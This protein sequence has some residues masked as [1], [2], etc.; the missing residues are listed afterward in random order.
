M[1]SFTVLFYYA[2]TD[3]RRITTYE[4]TLIDFH[5]TFGKHYSINSSRATF[6][7]VNV[8]FKPFKNKLLLILRN[9]DHTALL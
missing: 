2:K 9:L 4:M 7:F 1:F 6:K 5:E 8:L 3:S